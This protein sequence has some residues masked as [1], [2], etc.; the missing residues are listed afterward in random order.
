MVDAWSTDKGFDKFV[1]EKWRYYD[2]QGWGAYLLK[3]KFKSMKTYLK[4]WNKKVFDDAVRNQQHIINRISI[5]DKLD[6][7]GELGDEGRR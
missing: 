5:L 2:I 3:E 1:T 4:K 6:E 7:V